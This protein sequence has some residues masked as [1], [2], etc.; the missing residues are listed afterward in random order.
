VNAADQASVDRRRT[1]ARKDKAIRE[2]VIRSLMSNP[3]GR[4]Y[5]HL[6]LSKLHI[7]E[8]TIVF[9]PGGSQLTAFKE[10]KR[11]VGL[12][13][14]ADVTRLAP[15]EF[16]KMMVENSAIETKEEEHVDDSADS[17]VG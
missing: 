10:G 15:N 7:W 4:R 5:I 8:S 1:R 6:E 12:E 3:D 13:L 9:A 17:A 14:L 2:T 11:A 16:V